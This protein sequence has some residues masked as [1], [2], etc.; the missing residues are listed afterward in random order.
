METVREDEATTF[1]DGFVEAFSTFSGAMVAERYQTPFLAVD[2]AG[3]AT[4]F[5]TRGEIAKYFQAALDDYSTQGCQSCRYVNLEVRSLGLS[6]GL[7]TVTWE[8]LR[9]DGAVALSWRESYVVVRKSTRLAVCA[10][11]DHAA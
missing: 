4:A 10:S 9:G 3:A 1:F 8:L 7:L 5:T 11:I 6:S 2:A